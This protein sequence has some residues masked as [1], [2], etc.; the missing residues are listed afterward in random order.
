MGVGVSV[1][2]DEKG[3]PR[4]FIGSTKQR[5]FQMT[6]GDRERLRA[7]LAGK[8]MQGMLSDHMTIAGIEEIAK[9]HGMKSGHVLVQ[10]CREYAD[11]MLVELERT[12]ED[13]IKAGGTE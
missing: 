5:A 3:N 6:R 4:G 10:A 7:E 11:L 9:Q 1:M 13:P 12:A 2:Q 8:A